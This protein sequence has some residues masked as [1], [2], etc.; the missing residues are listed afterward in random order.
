MCNV[1]AETLLEHG[2]GVVK[3]IVG[4]RALDSLVHGRTS[5]GVVRFFEAMIFLF[6]LSLAYKR[7]AAMA[8]R[9]YRSR[10]RKNLGR[11]ESD[12]DTIPC[13]SATSRRRQ[14][15]KT[16]E[17]DG[18]LAPSVSVWPSDL[19]LQVDPVRFEGCVSV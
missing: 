10:R 18:L 12:S 9:A 5:S 16:A 13:T 1:H 7:G 11:N 3:S 14:G 15:R 4:E 2:K 17:Q 19:S 6:A 8:V